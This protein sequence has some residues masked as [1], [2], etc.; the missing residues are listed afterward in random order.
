MAK[1]NN[2]EIVCQVGDKAKSVAKL[3]VDEDDI[4]FIERLVDSGV[5]ENEPAQFVCKLSK[6]KYVT[7]PNQDLEIKWFI[8]G[9]EIDTKSENSRFSVEQID[10]VL[11]LNIK[12]VQA[13]DA[14]EI[15]CQVNG[16]IITSCNMAVEEEP[17]V[18]VKK[19]TDLVCE[20]IPGKVSF[21]CELNK[22]FVNAKWYRNGKEISNDDPKYDFGREG[23]KHFLNIRDVD[24]KDEAEYTIV[25]QG[26]VEKKCMATLSV[27]AP[28]K[29]FLNAKYNDTITIKR[30]QQLQI[31]VSFSGH[32]EPKLSWMLNDELL[33]ES[34]RTKIEVVKN[35]LA[36]LTVNKTTRSDS[37][38]YYLTLEN[39]YGREKCAIKVNV[40]D[41][42]APPKNPQVTEISGL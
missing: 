21:Q 5:K 4:K 32:P 1:D 30:G 41:R 15:K 27:K 12:S 40:L 39:D 6:L 14:G 37:G 16:T 26:K 18:F 31:D 19:L 25:L 20:E 2:A 9:K 23:P 11:K 38:K 17:V 36:L 28:P 29:L 3:R 33:K 22:S 7:R 24:G 34:A 13:E 10:T 35:N 42:P 8:N